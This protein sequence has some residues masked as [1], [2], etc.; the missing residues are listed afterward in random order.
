MC[1]KQKITKLK[2]FNHHVYGGKNSTIIEIARANSTRIDDLIE[3]GNLFAVNNALRVGIDPT[4]RIIGR[5]KGLHL[6]AS[7]EN[8]T[9]TF[10]PYLDLGFDTGKFKRSSFVIIS[11]N[12]Y[13]EPK[14][15][16]AVVGG[17]EKFRMTTGFANVRRVFFD[18][19]QR[20]AVFEYGVTLFHC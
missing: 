18:D 17:R 13:L 3:F 20:Y 5:A 15:E 6:G 12:L 7:E 19:T 8:E 10:V 16:L 9:A 2:F 11:K 14:Q 1:M 4:S